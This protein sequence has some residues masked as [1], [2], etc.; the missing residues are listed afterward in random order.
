M[1]SE[2]TP[3]PE[4]AAYQPDTEEFRSLVAAAGLVAFDAVDP[5]VEVDSVV[6]DPAPP[7]DAE[8]VESATTPACAHGYAT[9]FPL[10]SIPRKDRRASSLP[11]SVPQRARSLSDAGASGRECRLR[12][13]RDQ[14]RPRL[15]GRSSAAFTE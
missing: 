9:G 10:V 3:P 5:R 12:R 2:E 1:S 6:T 7:A 14:A 8:P 11:Q 13:L 4:I 15:L